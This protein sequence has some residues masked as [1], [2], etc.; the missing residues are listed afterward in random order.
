MEN[1]SSAP[2]GNEDSPAAIM[3]DI[4]EEIGK[5]MGIAPFVGSG[6]SARSGI[7]SG[8]DYRRYLFQCLK[9]AFDG[10][11]DPSTP[12]PRFRPQSSD[13]SVED[14]ALSWVRSKV[15]AIGDEGNEK[16]SALWQ[17]LGATADW[18]LTLNLLSRLRKDSSNRLG[19]R[20]SDPT[21]IDSFFVNL[22]RG[23]LPNSA[24]LLLAHLADILRIK[25][26]LTTNFDDLIESAFSHFD[27]PI[28]AFD[29]HYLAGL[30][31][32]RLVRAQRSVVKINGG[33]YG[34]RADLTL[35]REPH[36]M[37]REFFWEYLRYHDEGRGERSQ[38]YA[39]D[40]EFT[41]PSSRQL[42]GSPQ[43]HLLVM[44]LSCRETRSVNLI[45]TARQKVKVYWLCH[46]EEE[47]A[48]VLSAFEDA[49]NSKPEHLFVAV[50]P[51][52]SLFLLSLYQHLFHHLPP[53]GV[54]YAGHWPIPAPP[55][56]PIV[57]GRECEI[58]ELAAAIRSKKKGV[59][60]IHGGRGVTSVAAAAFE[61][62]RDRKHCVWIELDDQRGSGVELRG[63]DVGQMILETAASAA[64][65]RNELPRTSDGASK[66]PLDCQL[67]RL[68]ALVPR[69]VVAFLNLRRVPSDISWAE[70]ELVP[71]L[72]ELSP[73]LRV[74]LLVRDEDRRVL[75]SALHDDYQS[76]AIHGHA[77]RQSA[78]ASVE[79]VL[80]APFWVNSDEAKLFLLGLSFFRSVVYPSALHTP[81]VAGKWEN[82]CE[83]PQGHD[84]SRGEPTDHDA[85]RASWV[86]HWLASLRTSHVV[87]G[88]TGQPVFIHDD[89]RVAIQQSLLASYSDP[90]GLLRVARL[91]QG[92]ADW[93]TTLF[94][95]SQDANAGIEA[96]EH[97]LACLKAAHDVNEPKL[98][99]RAQYF[100][101]TSQ[102]EIRILLERIK[103]TTQN[104]PKP[105]K[106]ADPA[107]WVSKQLAS[108][109]AENSTSREIQL[110]TRTTHA[111]A[112]LDETIKAEMNARRFDSAHQRICDGLAETAKEAGLEADVAQ[113]LAVLRAKPSMSGHLGSVATDAK[114]FNEAAR[115]VAWTLGPVSDEALTL[116]HRFQLLRLYQAEIARRL[117]ELEGSRPRKI[118]Y[119]RQLLLKHAEGLYR[120]TLDLTRYCKD[121]ATS[122][123]FGGY[124]RANASIALARQCRY[125][126]ARRK[127]SEAYSCLSGSGSTS[128]LAFATV[129][130][131]RAETFLI[132]FD[133]CKGNEL[134]RFGYLYNA[135]ASIER[136]AYKTRGIH[137]TPFW[138][139]WLYELEMT[140]CVTL[141]K[142]QRMCR[143]IAKSRDIISVEDWFRTAF[144]N[145]YLVVDNDAYRCGR[146]IQLAAQ[147]RDELGPRGYLE[148][149]IRNCHSKLSSVLASATDLDEHVRAYCNIV[150]AGAQ[151]SS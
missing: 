53:A 137:V 143:K 77:F 3:E 56:D 9:D 103:T 22:T 91:R 118:E 43:R 79:E 82:E 125:Q 96:I 151:Y 11:W 73:H 89:V 128:A 131:R 130:L 21:I 95:S 69:G 74:A 59:V 94:S 97:R 27:M 49:H 122:R 144:E 51:D 17:A 115:Q 108:F 10:S 146:Y 6:M 83:W 29:V 72:R 40:G 34:L 116:F 12:W 129:D 71:L 20:D 138:L 104:R 80:K 42:L 142:N 36:Q 19:L 60:L 61:K 134:E 7:P 26:I 62:V 2:H 55:L 105:L 47:K 101:I 114:P 107:A 68:G 133:P 1:K 57:A 111:T 5:G 140:V 54:P 110:S 15:S 90:K 38:D 24:H 65:V 76:A 132:Q 99:R 13:M 14:E 148:E 102:R 63:R 127:H 41:P 8:N 120:A 150:S 136:A 93:Y 141:A 70:R 52:L 4:R 123:K 31:D 46:T 25:V 78:R 58:D 16:D 113:E 18:R 119:G 37:D 84:E 100:A 106:I 75:G 88:G 23:K 66:E 44:G 147:F 64:G 135:V 81:A 112:R 145:A 30:P 117:D 149:G 124:V 35:D 33:R 28:T 45:K 86:K 48:S 92:I 67:Q 85:C 50:V 121:D 32:P 126:E 87:R 139:S 98:L 39:T 109:P